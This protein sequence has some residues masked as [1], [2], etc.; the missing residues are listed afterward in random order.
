M[1]GGVCLKI[2]LVDDEQMYLEEIARICRKFGEENNLN[3]EISTF[4]D[5]ESFLSD[6]DH[7]CDSVV[8]MDIYMNGI[9]GV[10]AARSLRGHDSGCFLIF[11]TSSPDHMP[12][13]F[14]CH[15]F[16]YITKPFTTQRVTE[17]LRDV[18]KA[19]PPESKYMDFYSD[20][21]TVRI[22]F[23]ELI[24]VVTDAHYL[25]VE[26]VDSRALHCRMTMAQFMEQASND[27]RFILINK[28]IAVNADHIISLE[29][30]C[31]LLDNGTQLPIRVRNRLK[32]EQT[33]QNYNIDKIRSRQ[34][35][36]K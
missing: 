14:S 19:M 35:Y 30:N 5:G 1:Q 26:T 27:P 2:A 18:L 10:S 28:G 31:C 6:L 34:L 33:V 36:G 23:D 3:I 17:V 8:F 20:K 16:E 7:N 15:A 22:L 9:S 11:L 25:D 13:A 24:S 12:E 32:I 21:K 29:D 4:S